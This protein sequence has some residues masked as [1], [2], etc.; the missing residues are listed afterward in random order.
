MDTWSPKQLEM[1]KR[2]G[3][4]NCNS[5]LK[6]Y[7]VPDGLS[8]SQ[9]YDNAVARLY[10]E[11][12]DTISQGK[13]WS[14]AGKNPQY[15]A[16]S[17][18][19]KPNRARGAPGRSSSAS[20]SRWSDD[21]DDFD[22]WLDGKSTRSK[23]PESDGRIKDRRYEGKNETLNQKFST[24]RA[25]SSDAYFDR[26]GGAPRGDA[27]GLAGDWTEALSSGIT[28][29][30]QGIGGL[31]DAAKPMVDGVTE[32]AKEGMVKISE[33]ASETDW[34]EVSAKAES[35]VS[36]GWSMFSSIVSSAVESA[37]TIAKDA[38]FIEEPTG[39]GV[40]G[41]VAAR[42]GQERGSDSRFASES[43]GSFDAAGHNPPSKKSFSSTP[44]GGGA[45]ESKPGA[46]SS[47]IEGWDDDKWDSDGETW[48]DD[49][50][51]WG[52][53]DDSDDDSLPKPTIKGD[54]EEVDDSWS[55]DG[56]QPAAKKTSRFAES[57]TDEDE[58]WGGW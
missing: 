56:R 50:G 38:G 14:A 31:M 15:T 1:M 3:N 47:V 17:A 6:E 51:K 10:K 58:D 32:S 45:V 35:A 46:S 49:D 30:S 19:K 57:D 43:I 13:P 18:S 44:Y 22:A 16:P 52:K 23:P 11:K 53:L 40:L 54:D 48:S 12:I 28:S 26:G 2:G 27:G 33:S 36:S 8:I 7:G 42:A 39:N 24:A 41:E 4:D 34:D 5:F 55:N 20:S 29:I 25:I 21:G 37:Q 9:K